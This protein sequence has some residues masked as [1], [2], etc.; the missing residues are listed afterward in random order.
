[1]AEAIT[2]NSSYRNQAPRLRDIPDIFEAR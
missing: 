1:M 2:E